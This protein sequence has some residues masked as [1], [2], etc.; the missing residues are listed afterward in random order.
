MAYYSLR[1]QINKGKYKGKR[2]E[3]LIRDTDG[4]K[5]LLALHIG[6]YNVFLN[7]EVFR[8][9]ADYTR[10]KNGKLPIPLVSDTVCDNPHCVDGVVGVI[11]G[12]KVYCDICQSQTGR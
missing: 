12:E 7:P 9:L 3:E 4:Q 1:T 2:V 10:T 5:Y 6:D 11:Y 8:A